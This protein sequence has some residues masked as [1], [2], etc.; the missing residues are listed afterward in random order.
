MLSKVGCDVH[1]LVLGQL[2]GTS[3]VQEQAAQ[4][5]ERRLFIATARWIISA[6]SLRTTTIVSVS[7]TVII[8]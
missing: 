7:G 1:S 8:Y 5:R 6:A 3:D 4:L 2:G